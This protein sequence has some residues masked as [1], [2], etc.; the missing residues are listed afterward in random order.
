MKYYLVRTKPELVEKG[1]IGIGWSGF[2]FSEYE[3]S[4]DLIKAILNKGH[5]I[6]HYKPA[7]Q[8]F[9]K[10]EEGDVIVVPMHKSVVVGKVANNDFVYIEENKSI[11]RANQRRVDFLRDCST[12]K[13]IRIPR[14]D[15]DN[16]FQK[17]LKV[18]GV[19]VNDIPSKF[20][21]QIDKALEGKSWTERMKDEIRRLKEESGHTFKAALLN[22]IKNGQT[23]L[24][25]GGIGLEKLVNKL[26]IIDGYD[27]KIMGK[28][29][30]KSFA[31][32]D[33]HATRKDNAVSTRFK[34][35]KLLV[36]VKHHQ[37]ST[38]EWGIKQL[39]E[40]KKVHEVSYS[41]H[42]LVLVTSA[43]VSSGLQAKAKGFGIN[44]IDG[45]GLVDWIFDN[46]ESLSSDMKIILGIYE[47][48]NIISHSI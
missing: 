1:F 33:I 43:K 34:Q 13:L 14:T 48:P 16:D 9:F 22:R 46:V 37:G 4:G 7:I 31:D 15:F 26:L 36:Q 45:E 30:F 35:L 41:E 47:I 6:P 18:P 8:R 5:K 24:Q 12:G 20:S 17:K 42:Q 3:C 27:A 19:I 40:I 23:N 32:A 39:D 11:D 2:K 28:R 44:I 25:A 21:S 10:M 38:G 29:A